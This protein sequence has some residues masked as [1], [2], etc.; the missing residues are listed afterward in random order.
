MN[1]PFSVVSVNQNHST[2]NLSQISDSTSQTE[3]RSFF[4]V[5]ME[6][7][8]LPILNKSFKNENSKSQRNLNASGV[9]KNLEKEDSPVAR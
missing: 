5:R 4:P 9:L 1:Q 8:R 3:T 2:E 7:Y 6:K